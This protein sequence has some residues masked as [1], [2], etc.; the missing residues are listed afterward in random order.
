MDSPFSESTITFLSFIVFKAPSINCSSCERISCIE[1]FLEGFTYCIRTLFQRRFMYSSI[2]FEK[3]L[4]P[5]VTAS[6]CI[7]ELMIQKNSQLGVFLMKWSR[8]CLHYIIITSFLPIFHIFSLL[9]THLAL[10]KID[11]SASKY[12]KSIKKYEDLINVNRT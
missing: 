2:G 11:Q 8:S 12:E 5:S 4:W 3:C 1:V 10:A 6:I 7:M 9:F